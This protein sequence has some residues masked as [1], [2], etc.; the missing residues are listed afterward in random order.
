LKSCRGK[1][2]EL[3]RLAE[4]KSGGRATA[5][6]SQISLACETVVVAVHEHL[7]TCPSFAFF[8]AGQHRF[9]G[10]PRWL[11]RHAVGDAALCVHCRRARVV[12]SEPTAD[13][14]TEEFIELPMALR[15]RD[16]PE[17]RDDGGWCLARAGFEP[18]EPQSLAPTLPL[19]HITSLGTR[20]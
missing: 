19:A 11:E 1:Q 6:A 10:V 17:A 4:A 14:E 8:L 12:P 9:H 5:A 7:E 3:G 16:S 20:C 13:P 18:E 2:S 15:R